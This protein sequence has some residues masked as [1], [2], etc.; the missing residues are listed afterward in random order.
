MA[1]NVSCQ[2]A[3]HLS[4]LTSCP[5]AR[6]FGWRTAQLSHT[7]LPMTCQRCCAAHHRASSAMPLAA[8]TG[9]TGRAALHQSTPA[10]GWPRSS[11]PHTP[12][13][14]THA[15][16]GGPGAADSAT[17]LVSALVLTC[18]R[19]AMAALAL[20][21]LSEQSFP[22]DQMEVGRRVRCAIFAGYRGACDGSP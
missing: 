16:D 10:G 20:R 14:A 13:P 19:H 12:S 22:K 2:C 9:G 8:T 17:L 5:D 18:N 11:D 4:A 6:S 7:T 21:Q 15:T 1:P 3:G